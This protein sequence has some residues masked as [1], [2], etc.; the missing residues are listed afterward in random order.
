[1]TRLTALLSKTAQILGAV[2]ITSPFGKGELRGISFAHLRGKSF[3]KNSRNRPLR[4][5]TGHAFSKRGIGRC[6]VLLCV[7]AVSACMVGPDYTRPD[8][9]IPSGW[10][11]LNGDPS[12]VINE[13]WWS[14]FND[15]QLD[16]LIDVALAENMDI[17]IASARVEEA[18]ALVTISRAAL[19]PQ[20]GTS[21]SAGRAR[22]STGATPLPP[23]V[24]AT[25]NFYSAALDTSFELDLWG[26]L[27]R[28][29][30]AARAA[31]LSTQY[32]ELVVRL[33]LVNQVAQSYFELRSFDLQLEIARRTLASREE[34]LELVT[35]RF[36]GGVVSEL[37][38]QQAES[39]A[40][41][42]AVAVPNLEQQ[43]VQRENE[44]SVLLGRNPEDIMRGR[45]VFEVAI[46]EVPVGLPSTLLVRRPDILA[47]EQSLVAANA[48]IGA[49]RAEYFP[50]ISLTGLLGFESTELSDW[51]NRGSRIWQ[52]AGG[53][54]API[55]TAGRIGAQVDVA[56]AQQ[57]QSL[58]DYL[59][60]IQT[61][62][63]E[64]E[65]ALIAIRKIREQQIAQD[66][67]IQAFQR[68]L[69]LANLRYDNGY[70]G[71]LEVLDAQRNLFNAEL[72][73]VQLQSARLRAIV[74]LYRA[75]GG[76]WVP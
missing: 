45:G 58:Y 17:R 7:L 31:L 11:M 2:R 57:Q 41:G 51:F 27:R 46:P 29:T 72:Q 25:N 42:A 39:E 62:F 49:A 4:L 74:D 53:L 5:G 71:Y 10:R 34:S 76:G 65:D 60:T 48:R 55:F 1:M 9:M 35:K 75:L 61:G 26:R 24:S 73:Q 14:Q 13:Q 30:E 36:R 44:L 56:T 52:V 32:A 54:T 47:A 3:G 15:P 16:R 28:G 6:A 37:D 19:F 63:R 69:R 38:L 67:Q 18:R 22:T 70:S 59:L 8:A 64:V 20:I 33:S 50:R 23:G 68:T 43:I 21:T 40:A 66:R 12:A